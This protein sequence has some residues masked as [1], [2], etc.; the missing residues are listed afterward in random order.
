MQVSIIDFY[1]PCNSTTNDNEN[2]ST[3]QQYFFD[4]GHEIDTLIIQNI[5]GIILGSENVKSVW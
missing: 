1:V 2:I 4:L 3:F 5:D